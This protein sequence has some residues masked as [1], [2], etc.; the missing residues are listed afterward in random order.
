MKIDIQDNGIF[1]HYDSVIKINIKDEKLTF[2]YIDQKGE[3]HCES[4]NMPDSVIVYR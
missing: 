1:F 4:G 3:E 2:N